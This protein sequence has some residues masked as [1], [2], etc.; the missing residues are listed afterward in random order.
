[1]AIGQLCFA[2]GGQNCLS[3]VSNLVCRI[4]SPFFDGT[5]F[6]RDDSHGTIVQDASRKA[7][8]AK[9]RR[10][11]RSQ[12]PRRPLRELV[13]KEGLFQSQPL[14][15]S[16]LEA[17]TGWI[18]HE[19]RL[20]VARQRPRSGFQ[21][22]QVVCGNTTPLGKGTRC[23]SPVASPRQ[24]RGSR[25]EPYRFPK[26]ALMQTKGFACGPGRRDKSREGPRRGVG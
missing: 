24:A 3:I 9:S 8:P 11:L 17:A 4:V 12:F 16:M 18:I 14:N 10:L 7:G 13:D 5:S 2:A 23:A 6:V 19:V 15:P 26:G 1:M 20:Y 25:V 22:L 21:R